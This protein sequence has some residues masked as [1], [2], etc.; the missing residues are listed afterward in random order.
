MSKITVIGAGVMGST[1]AFPACDNGHSVSLVGTPYDREIIARLKQDGYHLGLKRKLPGCLSFYQTEEL[2][3]VLNQSELVVAG[4]SSFGV[5]W[6]AD[7][8]LPQIKD[9]TPVL[10]VT[11]GLHSKGNGE[12]CSFVDY[13]EERCCGRVPF[14]AIGGPCISH[15][16]ADR[17]D[18][19]VGI[20]GYSSENLEKIRNMLLTP[21]YHI[22]T[23]T[24]VV[25]FEI[26]AA[27]KNI[28][29]LAVSMAIGVAESKDGLG[30][31][32]HFNSQSGL[33][34]QSIREMETIIKAFGG[35]PEENI[36]YGVADLYITI[37]SGRNREIGV[38]LGRGYTVDEALEKLRGM[39]LESVSAV[40]A[41]SEALKLKCERGEFDINSI[42]LFAH[43]NELMSGKKT[44]D[45]PWDNF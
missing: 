42:P 27:I 6:F 4:I 13:F 44:V 35:N 11:K 36:V 32:P 39:T 24:D 21:Y 34:A 5:D 22:N 31:R 33:F 14:Y 23:T 17:H 12:L 1:V 19:F 25:G 20:C 45:I 16:L 29:A 37:E 38:L 18:T 3:E 41:L 15:E 2:E 30:C 9:G 28:Y 7:E 40:K 43:V 26:A 8:I 10:L